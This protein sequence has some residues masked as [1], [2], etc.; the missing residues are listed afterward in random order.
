MDAGHQIPILKYTQQVFLMDDPFSGF[1]NF[2]SV[3]SQIGSDKHNLGYECRLHNF[4]V[5]RRE[6]FTRK[7]HLEDAS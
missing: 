7:W 1:F 5:F 4:Y 2:L 3:F 6:W